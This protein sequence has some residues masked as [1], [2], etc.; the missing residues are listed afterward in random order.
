MLDTVKVGPVLSPDEFELFRRFIYQAAGIDMSPTK[1]ALVQSRLAP[2][3]R[4]LKCQSYVQY[5]RILQKPES[6]GE[7]EQA[8]NLLSTNETYFFREPRHFDWLKQQVEQAS[9]RRDKPWRVWSAASS[10]GEEAYSIAITLAESLGVDGN[11]QVHATDINTRVT[12]YAQRAIYPVERV[13][14][15][16]PHLWRQY[17]Q[18]GNAEYAGTIRVKPE[19][20]RKVSFGNVNLLHSEQTKMTDFDV[21]FL[22]NVMIYFD[23]ETKFRVVQQLCS[24]LVPGGYLIIGHAETIRNL[25]LDLV[26]EAPSR[27][28]HEVGQGRKAEAA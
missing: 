11:W 16:P 6:Q 21:I 1:R 19:I 17:F 5:H 27:Y 24:K 7:R 4:A 20:V 25:G 28:R 14:H 22:R 8:I 23:E 18:R 15:T 3:L 10:T 12:Q 9:S 2:R 26:Q 13:R